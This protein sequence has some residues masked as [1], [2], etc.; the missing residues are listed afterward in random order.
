M[1]GLTL[2]LIATVIYGAV[3]AIGALYSGLKKLLGKQREAD[4]ARAGPEIGRRFE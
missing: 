3:I 1:V 4:S 2:V